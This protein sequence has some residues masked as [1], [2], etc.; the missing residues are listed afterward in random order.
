MTK[1][2]HH[3]GT[4]RENFYPL[5]IPTEIYMALK[6]F[7]AYHDLGRGHA[8]LYLLNEELNREHA[9]ES[10]PEHYG[11]MKEKY[12]VNLLEVVMRNREIRDAEREPRIEGP[13]LPTT[14]QKL[15]Q[16][17]GKCYQEHCGMDA[18]TFATYIRT[19]D[20]YPVCRSHLEECR[21]NPE[22]WKVEEESVKEGT[23]K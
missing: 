13:V 22:K 11:Q 3:R 10:H 8:I 5:R 12:Y 4:S 7:E 9:Y 15:E 23:K 17:L 6:R 2:S 21:H 1:H 20:S 14:E 16:E 19:G 18:I